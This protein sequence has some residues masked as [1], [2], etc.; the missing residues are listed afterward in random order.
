MLS[1]LKDM[2]DISEYLDVDFVEMKK[3]LFSKNNYF[4]FDIPKKNG[5]MRTISAP[6]EKL[7]QIQRALLEKLSSAYEPRKCV[8]GFVKGKSILTNAKAHIENKY[9][10]NLDLKDF[11]PTI[12]FNRIKRLL[13]SK[14]FNASKKIA[15]ILANILTHNGE[16]PQGACTSPLISN[17]ICRRLDNRLYKFF[18]VNNAHYSRYADDISIS[19]NDDIKL[20]I[21]NYRK[22]SINPLIEKIINEEGFKI[23]H[24]KTKYSD[25]KGHKEVTGII[26][27]EKINSRKD[28]FYRLKSMINDAYKNGVEDA[29]KHYCEKRNLQFNHEEKGKFIDVLLGTF[30]FYEMLVNEDFESRE[31]FKRIALKL[32]AILGHGYCD[33]KFSRDELFEKACFLLKKRVKEE[34][35]SLDFGTIFK[36]DKYFVTCKHCLMD[37]NEFEHLKIFNNEIVSRVL[38]KKYHYTFVDEKGREVDLGKVYVSEK[39]DIALFFNPNYYLDVVFKASKEETFLNDEIEIFGFPDYLSGDKKSRL[40]GKISNERLF[41]IG[42]VGTAKIPFFTTDAP[43]ITGNSGGPVINNKNEVIGV[44]E[45]GSKD[46]IFAKVEN[47]IN[48]IKYVLEEIEYVD[49]INYFK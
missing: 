40:T 49:S 6:K 21:Y 33:I 46:R 42:D 1:K 18:D 39:Y 10:L 48:K 15:N 2:H 32:N 25:R 17:M 34:D 35:T 5:E 3:V 9:L 47:G 13:M 31:R 45:Y 41:N 27:N 28:Y 7:G 16:L 11:F 4:S 12:N 44:V 23:N 37:N 8:N 24:K 19:W 43:I 36:M 22:K 38:Q 30:N 20:C 14:E 29:Y 26:I